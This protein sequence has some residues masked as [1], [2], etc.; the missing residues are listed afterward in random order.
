MPELYPTSA[1]VKIGINES[2]AFPV[3]VIEQSEPFSVAVEVPVGQLEKWKD[4][5]AE[6]DRCQKEMSELFWANKPK[7]SPPT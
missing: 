6:F 3:Y 5:E 4:A 2:E 7:D 1:M